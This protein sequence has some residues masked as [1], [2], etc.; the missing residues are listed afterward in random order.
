MVLLFRMVLLFFL[1]SHVTLVAPF[2]MPLCDSDIPMNVPFTIRNKQPL[3][4]TIQST[5]PDQVELRN[6]VT[7]DGGVAAHWHA[8]AHIMI[9]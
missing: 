5:P 3:T 4:P 1:G 2:M 9:R 7:G 6:R 8:S